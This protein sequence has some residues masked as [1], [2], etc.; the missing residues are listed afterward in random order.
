MH[1]IL[2]AGGSI[3]QELTWVLLANNQPVR[4]VSR[5]P[6]PI[7]DTTTKAADL[8]DSRQ[9]SEAVKGSSIVYLCPGLTYDIKVWT[10]MWPAIMQTF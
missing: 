6:K 2:G 4:L 8:T 1:T 7:Q 10:K 9:T 3:A 5:N